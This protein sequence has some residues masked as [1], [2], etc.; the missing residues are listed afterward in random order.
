MSNPT[1]PALPETYWRLARCTNC[2][3][4]GIALQI[5]AGTPAQEHAGKLTCPACDTHG[6][7]EAEP[8][9]DE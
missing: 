7:I 4:N 2:G 3:C 6:S 9:K 5:A 8:E 1:L